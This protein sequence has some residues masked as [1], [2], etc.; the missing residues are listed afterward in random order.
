MH[1]QDPAG[2]QY[3]AS[4]FPLSLMQERFWFLEHCEEI[5]ACNLPLAFEIRGFLDVNA[6]EKSLA[7][8]IRRHE[9]LRTVIV[10]GADGDFQKHVPL[11]HFRLEIEDIDQR[12]LD[13]YLEKESSRRFDLL[14]GPLFTS[15][16]LR[17]GDRHHILMLNQHRIIADSHSID[18]L[19]RE[20]GTAYGFLA[21]STAPDLPAVTCTHEDFAR[22][23]RTYLESGEFKSELGYWKETLKNRHQLTLPSDFSPPPVRNCEGSSHR[24]TLG[25]NLAPSLKECARR[26]GT[27]LRLLLLTALCIFAGRWS[28][29]KA[30]F[31]GL[32]V[33]GRGEF[34]VA[35]G[36]RSFPLPFWADLSG[37]PD[38]HTLVERIGKSHGVAAEHQRVPFEY[39]AD[40][41]QE[42]SGLDHFHRPEVLCV[43][44]DRAATIALGDLRAQAL[45]TPYVISRGG[46]EFRFFDEEP[47]A[48]SLIIYD[49]DLYAEDSIARMA[50]HFTTILESIASGELREK[51][52]S[53]IPM[54][55]DHEKCLIL[56]QW[57]RTQTSHGRSATLQG[58]F[59]EQAE[60]MPDRVALYSG[61]GA[62][63]FRELNEKA[64]QAAYAIKDRF[65]ARSG[66]EIRKETL[67]G[68]CADRSPGMVIGMLA[69]LK[70][71]AACVLLNGR[72]PEHRLRSMVDDAGVALILTSHRDT[73]VASSLRR[74]EQDVLSLDHEDISRHPR[75]NPHLTNVP[76][77]LALVIHISG[78][79]KP[80][81]VMIEH[82]NLVSLAENTR[83]AAGIWE[84]SRVLHC[85]SI[86]SPLMLAEIFPF[87]LHGA[88]L[89][90]ASDEMRREPAVLMK[91]L[92]EHA[93]THL[94]TTASSLAAIPCRKIP[95]LSTL[96]VCGGPCPEK[97]IDFWRESAEVICTHGY[98]ECTTWA[99]AASAEEGPLN[100][101]TGR[102]MAGVTLHVLDSALAP[103]PI[104]VPGELFIGGEGVARGYLNRRELTR[105]RFIE[106]PAASEGGSEGGSCVLY[107]TG[108]L[109]RWL[110]DGNLEML[111][112]RDRQ[113]ILRG[114]RIEPEEI[115][116]TLGDHPRI[117]ACAVAAADHCGR[118]KLLCWFA[119][120]DRE[121]GGEEL[122]AY[123]AERLPGHMIPEEFMPVQTIPLTA[124]GEIDH[125]A[126]P[127]PPP[128][129]LPGED[130]YEA[131]WTEV[132]RRLAELAE[133][134][135]SQQRIGIRDRLPCSGR[136]RRKCITLAARAAEAGIE[137]TLKDIV[138][139]GEIA[140]LAE[141][142]AGPHAPAPEQNIV[143]GYA[144]L[145]PI[146]R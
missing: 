86:D 79:G 51:K 2:E 41:L 143:S 89:V 29:Q 21:A 85:A 82:R 61:E 17:L 48:E 64:N 133:E 47:E 84:Q 126:L 73:A 78:P 59:E 140:R 87:L 74:G 38:F 56:G 81:G 42:E 45:E 18:I 132:E 131:P 16:L 26:E 7:H 130:C 127:P 20:L 118:E 135:F 13:D 57:N 71:G 83:I 5:P 43:F 97:V 77:D 58:L 60:K 68:L 141:C 93:I 142:A 72:Y 27:S 52:I 136:A 33:S 107:R 96:L 95:S 55:P 66:E 6:L 125:D 76:G 111:G 119:P 80:A 75:E 129:S 145:T 4:Q 105:E 28:G 63:C 103:T 139:L 3:S 54:M 53:E 23:E 65:R 37:D 14:C 123:L 91:A 1:T 50:S 128:Y 24:F 92:N 88:G 44:R 124:E 109:V 104:G 46:I 100:G 137:V 101:M 102:Q 70:S 90:I 34:P 40:V 15:R 10:P 110:P 113:I 25:Q 114:D 106:Y 108:D 120:G 134:V 99:T 116:R 32:E 121:I 62:L 67:I 11:Q 69:I 8:L 122:R 49:R 36:P 31:L 138:T 98:A 35:Y 12:Q 39:I 30:F 22:W 146:H 94:I 115:E 144:P 112:R 9:I 117:K 19:L